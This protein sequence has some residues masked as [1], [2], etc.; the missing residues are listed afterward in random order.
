[1]VDARQGWLR[2]LCSRRGAERLRTGQKD[3]NYPAS[4]APETFNACSARLAR[5]RGRM[6]ILQR[7]HRW[8][9]NI[10]AP[11]NA[12][13]V[14]LVGSAL[15]TLDGWSTTAY[16]STSFNGSLDASTSMARPSR[17]SNST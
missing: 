7:V 15:N 11:A 4:Q 9:V 13:P 14:T 16:S 1:M 10:P 17:S 12:P 2:L 6:T 5:C 8:N 3:P